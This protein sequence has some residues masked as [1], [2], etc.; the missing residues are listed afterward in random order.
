MLS[1]L[2]LISFMSVNR[3]CGMILKH[4]RQNIDEV[5]LAYGIMPVSTVR[6]VDN[7]EV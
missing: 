4:A 3:K 6:N 1:G 5:A 7:N 2:R